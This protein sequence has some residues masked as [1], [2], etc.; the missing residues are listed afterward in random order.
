VMGDTGPVPVGP[1]HV[2][3]RSMPDAGEQP[4]RDRGRRHARTCSVLAAAGWTVAPRELVAA[5]GAVRH[6]ETGRSA[7]YGDL[8]RGMRRV[9]VASPGAALTPGPA[10]QA[11]R[12]PGRAPGHRAGHRDGSPALSIRPDPSGDAPWAGASSAGR[13]RDTA[14]RSTSRGRRDA[15]RDGRPGGPFV[16][17]AHRTR[18]ARRRALGAI[19]AAGTWRPTVR[20][21]PRRAPAHASAR[22]SLGGR[23]HQELGDLEAALATA[24]VTLQATYTTAY[25]AHVPSRRASPWRS[26]MRLG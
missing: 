6:R 24:P 4:S 2:R 10:E 16:G 18:S 23:I 5:D 19:E 14:D 22:D 8:V 26:G 7:T 15:G 13:R 1:G 21:R 11:G 3:S 9:A 25:I 12:T 20:D 17:V